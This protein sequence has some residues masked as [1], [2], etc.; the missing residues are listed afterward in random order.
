MPRRL[1]RGTSRHRN[2]VPGAVTVVDGGS[3]E[4]AYAGELIARGALARG[5]GGIVVD[6]GYR[7]ITYV[8]NCELPIYSRFVTPMAGTTTE[9]GELQI[10]I[11]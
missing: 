10:P 7:D 6:G 11:T 8:R 2:G 9:L 5:L 3:E 4:I 1:L